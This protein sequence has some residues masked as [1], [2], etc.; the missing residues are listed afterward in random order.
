MGKSVVRTFWL[1]LVLAGFGLLAGVSRAETYHLGTG[2]ALNGE[3][4]PASANDQ[5]VQVKVAE[6]KYEKVAWG[7][8][9]QEDLRKFRENPK[10]EP[11]VEPFIEVTAEER[12]KK[13]E[14]PIKQP[15]RLA[16]PP[17]RSFFT[18]MFSSSLGIA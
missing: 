17:S 5:G 18:A 6:G 15:T 1:I 11:F 16:H 13:T 3:M 7:N 9:S 12:V 14:V 4:L 8:F 10:L 2:E